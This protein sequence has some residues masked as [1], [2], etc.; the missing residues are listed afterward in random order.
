ML[1]AAAR[2][3]IRIMRAPSRMSRIMPAHSTAAARRRTESSPA[4]LFPAKEE[5]RS[6]LE[7]LEA[8]C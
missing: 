2:R 5:G 4:R 6:S 3:A 1:D 7:V 8:F